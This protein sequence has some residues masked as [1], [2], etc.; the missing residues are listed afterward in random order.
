MTV[1]G[2]GQ[3][4]RAGDAD[5]RTGDMV[6]GDA[7]DAELQD[8]EDVAVRVGVVGEDVG[9]DDATLGRHEGVVGRGRGR[10]DGRDR[11]IEA[12]LR[13]EGTVG[14]RVGD[15]RDGAE[16]LGDRD[17]AVAA[18]GVDAD[19]TDAAEDHGSAGGD[20]LSV[21]GEGGHR[22]DGAVDVGIVGEDVADRGR[23]LED[24]D[25][26]VD[27]DRGV[28]D[29]QDGERKGADVG[30]HAVG[31]G[32]GDARDGA[33][34]VR[35][36]REDEA[37]VG[38]DHERALAGDDRGVARQVIGAADGELHDVEDVG[39]D[40]AVVAEDVALE[41]GVFGAGG[42][43][44]G[45]L[46]GVVDGDHRD[47]EDRRGGGDAVGHHVGHA[48]DAAVEV[49]GGDEA[50]GARGGDGQRA[51]S[52][53]QGGGAER[54]R[55]GLAGDRVGDDGQVVA[56]DVE[57][58]GEQAAADDRRVLEE[59]VGVGV[60][61]RGVVDRS[62]DEG[63]V[64]D[65]GGEAVGDGHRDGADGAMEVEDRLEH[66]GSVG[67]DGQGA[68]PCDRRGGARGVID[69]RDRELLDGE[70]VGF[71][72]GVVGEDGAGEDGVLRRGEG[73]VDG[74]DGVVGARD[75]DDHGLLGG[76]AVVVGHAD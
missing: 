69:A 36:G 71:D 17:E 60:G 30:R 65:V 13:G 42:D 51:D 73:V 27:A 18:V 12:R 63:E 1:G 66:V 68:L 48:R 26:V 21:H 3:E 6:T 47:A 56:V 49:G 57:V 24:H 19:G 37:A 62:Q 50:V 7:G 14:G 38:A 61:D 23:V 64:G 16:P 72:V 32:V 44:V 5:G 33:V 25:G 2:D 55:T 53:D 22:R 39:V 9:G 35:E 74:E 67:A 43:V 40:V 20:G 8:R 4:A 70:R 58:V 31:D 54:E 41:V 34:E 46:R 59:R 45:R 28:V 76:R 29:G 10:V 52:R 15:R 11:D 75:R